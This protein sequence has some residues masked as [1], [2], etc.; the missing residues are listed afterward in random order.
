MS[1]MRKEPR[2]ENEAA[3][4]TPGGSDSGSKIEQNQTK[5]KPRNDRASSA[6][7]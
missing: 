4:E 3:T 5:E 7:A 1:W 6:E 2:I